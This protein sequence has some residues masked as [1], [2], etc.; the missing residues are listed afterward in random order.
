M[1]PCFRR[2]APATGAVRL[3]GGLLLACALVGGGSARAED[4]AP[5][6]L[7]RE[8]RRVVR[9]DLPLAERTAAA[10]AALAV[11]VAGDPE[12][13]A[14]AGMALLGAREDERA[15]WMLLRATRE[16]W[17]PAD[18]AQTELLALQRARWSQSKGVGSNPPSPAFAA[19]ELL[20]LDDTVSSDLY[21]V[22]PPSPLVTECLADVLGR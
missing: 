4:P 1:T 11:K 16:G 3:L 10:D 21:D 7:A 5:V 15:A 12:A 19:V 9:S 18:W 22:W 6:D 13:W 14:R 20:L 8:L 2:V 17:H